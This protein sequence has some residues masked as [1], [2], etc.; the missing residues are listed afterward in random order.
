M[1]QFPFL[2][3]TS[4]R[5]DRPSGRSGRVA[6]YVKNEFRIKLSND[7]CNQSFEC[8][9]LTLRP[10]WLPRS[11]ARIAVACVYLPP[12]I[13]PDTLENFHDYFQ[14]CYDILTTENSDTAVIVAGDFNLT[15]NGFNPKILTEHCSLKQVIKKPTRNAN[16]LDL[17]FTN[18][19]SYFEHPEILALIS[20]SDHNLIIWK[21]KIQIPRKNIK[22]KIKVRPVEALRTTTIQ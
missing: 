4:F 1:R 2:V 3:S 18:K 14:S 19:N 22:R 7:I 20:S 6:I 9:W 13:T 11:I 10:K 15:G 21:S 5:K 8:L 12:S 17:I 16:I